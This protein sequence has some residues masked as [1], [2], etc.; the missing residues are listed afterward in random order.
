MPQPS[1]DDQAFDSTNAFDT[2]A[3]DFDTTGPTP[4]VTGDFGRRRVASF[5]KRG[6]VGTLKGRMT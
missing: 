2:Q 1:F 5:V 4:T 3:F 6:G